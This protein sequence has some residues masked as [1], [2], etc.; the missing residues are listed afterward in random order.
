MMVQ[1]Q[2][3]CEAPKPPR[4]EC[5]FDPCQPP[6]YVDCNLVL[7]FRNPYGTW[8]ICRSTGAWA[9]T[10]LESC[11]PSLNFLLY[12]PATGHFWV[13]IGDTWY[14]NAAGQWTVNNSVPC[15][16]REV[17]I[18]VVNGTMFYYPTCNERTLRTNVD[19][20]VF[21]TTGYT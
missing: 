14:T 16:L 21:C 2:A 4:Y 5:V 20:N 17:Y 9:D 1:S 12:D 3:I 8:K 11:P 18:N 6:V 7:W 10:E 15:G 13:K 19:S